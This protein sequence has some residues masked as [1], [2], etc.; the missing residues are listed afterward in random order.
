MLSVLYLARLGFTMKNRSLKLEDQ[1]IN[2]SIVT[3]LIIKWKECESFQLFRFA[4]PTETP[5]AKTDV[6]VHKRAPIP[7]SFRV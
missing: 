2:L 3:E 4:T 5:S 1:L 7:N 6:C